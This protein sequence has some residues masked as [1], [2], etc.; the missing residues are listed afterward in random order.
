MMTSWL[1]P[2]PAPITRCLMESVEHDVVCEGRDILKVL[3]F[4]RISCREA[5]VLA[6][7]RERDRCI[8]D[9]RIVI[10]RIMSWRSS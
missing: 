7:S 4:R 8:A 9:G 6:L 5:L 10:H 2:V 1:T 3:P